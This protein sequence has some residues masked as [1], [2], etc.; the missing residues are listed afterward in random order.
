MV[1]V[2]QD[3]V[4]EDVPV[5]VVRHVMLLADLRVNVV[6]VDLHTN[7]LRPKLAPMFERANTIVRARESI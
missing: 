1:L 7:L 3:F 2:P 6:D 5:M 4:E